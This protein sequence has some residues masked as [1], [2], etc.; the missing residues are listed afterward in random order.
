V[1]PDSST[2]LQERWACFASQA[3]QPLTC[4][5]CLASSGVNQRPAWPGTK[6]SAAVAGGWEGGS[7]P[8]T[9]N[10]CRMQEGGLD[11]VHVRRG[12]KPQDI[13]RR[14]STTRFPL[15][16][17]NALNSEQA[18]AS[19]RV[20][21]AHRVALVA[22]AVQVGRQVEGGERF[23]CGEQAARCWAASGRGRTCSVSHNS[24][25]RQRRAPT[26]QYTV[27][28]Q[29][30]EQQRP[31]SLPPGRPVGVPPLAVQLPHGEPVL[32]RQECRPT[33]RL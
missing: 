4:V 24:W 11:E 1:Q 17:T 15:L 18:K 32:L 14:T 9:T 16:N 2:A 3:A 26:H 8:L 28:G 29:R 30:G 23:G 5:A 25:Q 31:P 13:V 7:G 19:L 33:E 10:I 22:Q 6:R 21:Q 12:G 27:R 20:Q